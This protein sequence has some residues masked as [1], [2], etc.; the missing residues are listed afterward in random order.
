VLRAIRRGLIS[1]T[2]DDATGGW[3][4]E[5]S[6][7]HRVY[8]PVALRTA[9]DALRNHN[10]TDATAELRARLDAAEAAVRFRDEVI[11]DL[12]QQRD[13]EAEERRRL[14]AVISNMRQEPAR[15]SWWRWGRG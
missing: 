5:P 12:R 10:G 11:A 14:T 4:I 13:R 9:D 1:A 8:P 6:E 7:L 2:R 3:L 15:R